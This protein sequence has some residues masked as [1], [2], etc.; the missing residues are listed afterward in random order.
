MLM[1][2]LLTKPIIR[3]PLSSKAASCGLVTS[4]VRDANKTF[5]TIES[6]G[7]NTNESFHGNQ[8]QRIEKKL[9][10]TKPILLNNAEKSRRKVALTG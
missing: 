3:K 4:E 7:I 10:Q 8:D 1:L 6:K 5:N 9:G 2:A